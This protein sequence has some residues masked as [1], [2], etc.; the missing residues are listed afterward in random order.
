MIV[1]NGPIHRSKKVK[2]FL[3]H[4]NWVK[5]YFLPS[6]SPEYNPIE[7]FWKWLKRTVHGTRSYAGIQELI[8]KLRQVVWHYNDM[9]NLFL[10]FILTL[11]ACHPALAQQGYISSFQS[12]KIIAN[13]PLLERQ[14]NLICVYTDPKG[15]V[16]KDIVLEDIAGYW[17]NSPHRMWDPIGIESMQT[18]V[19]IP[20]AKYSYNEIISD[21]KARI[22]AKSSQDV[23][24][25]LYTQKGWTN[26]T[27]DVYFMDAQVQ[28]PYPFKRMIVFGDSLSDNSNDFRYI[29][30]LMAWKFGGVYWNKRFS[31]GLV[32]ADW[33]VGYK[34]NTE[35]GSGLDIPSENYAFGGAFSI[36]ENEHIIDSLADQVSDY[37]SYIDNNGKINL[38]ADV[39][40]TLYSLLIGGNDFLYTDHSPQLVA[41][42]VRDQMERLIARGARYFLI[43][44]FP[45]VSQ[46]PLA[47]ERH[48]VTKLQ[49]DVREYNVALQTN[50]NEVIQENAAKGITIIVL[51]PD[52]NQYLQT[53]IRPVAEN[54]FGFVTD[55][56][57]MIDGSVCQEPAKYLFWDG[58][59]P[60]ST[61][62][63]FMGKKI[64][65]YIQVALHMPE[66]YK[67]ANEQQLTEDEVDKIWIKQCEYSYVHLIIWKKIHK[68]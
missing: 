34:T 66:T 55:K 14:A 37:F 29:S 38:S 65:T 18:G 40:H 56:A 57:C 21:C 58:L 10:L 59:H 43:P 19:F 48:L 17:I 36:G 28:T 20:D 62:A 7:L 16:Y 24:V 47:K 68:S 46:S 61:L 26:F 22:A 8:K 45:D 2:K 53:L 33:V 67:T 35:L 32:W 1:D 51:R 23:L 4:N 25:G 44:V 31:N 30:V 49:R 41:T 13:A 6:Y 9:R 50:I 27:H 60:N 64:T 15:N 52:I 5:L 12:A 54:N 39:P 11:F 3:A 42:E 63:C